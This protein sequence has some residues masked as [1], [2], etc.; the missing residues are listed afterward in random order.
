MA[1]AAR[2]AYLSSLRTLSPAA[3]G[4]R[5]HD[6][7]VAGGGFRVGLQRAG[8]KKS[9]LQNDCDCAALDM[10][11]LSIVETCHVCLFTYCDVTPIPSSLLHPTCTGGVLPADDAHIFLEVEDLAGAGLLGPY[12]SKTFAVSHRLS[13]T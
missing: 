5:G 4:R 7:G 8:E 12:Q 10:I 2:H 9:L 1:T 3:Q 6:W 11:I 13:L